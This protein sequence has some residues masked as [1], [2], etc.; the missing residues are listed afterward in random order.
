[1]PQ[2]ILAPLVIDCHLPDS[3]PSVLEFIAQLDDASLEA[4]IVCW[5]YEAE[6][7]LMGN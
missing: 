4:G 1:M 7:E 2:S 5:A 3:A 6:G